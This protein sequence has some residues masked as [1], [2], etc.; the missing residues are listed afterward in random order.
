MI[1]WVLHFL[2]EYLIV[3]MLTCFF[4]FVFVF[5][6]QN[7]SLALVVSVQRDS[8]V[9]DVRQKFPHAAVPLVRMGPPVQTQRVDFNVSV[10]TDIQV[11]YS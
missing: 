2:I 9:S 10:L 3:Q 6:R 1:N 5:S 7:Q 8:Q 11:R 4:A